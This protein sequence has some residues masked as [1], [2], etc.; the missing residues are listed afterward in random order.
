MWKPQLLRRCAEI[1]GTLEDARNAFIKALEVQPR[2]IGTYSNLV[3]LEKF[4]PENPLFQT[5][6]RIVERVKN[7]KVRPTWRCISRSVRPMTTWANT[8]RRSTTSQ[9]ARN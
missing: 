1:G 5:M 4:T 8:R 9:S 2:A 7:A 3:D 6:Q